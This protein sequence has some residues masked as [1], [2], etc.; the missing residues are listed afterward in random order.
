MAAEM[1]F[2]AAA[3]HACGLDF[4]AADHVHAHPEFFWQEPLL[5]DMN[6]HPWTTFSAAK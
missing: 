5:R 6:S 2:V 4:K 3:G 1:S